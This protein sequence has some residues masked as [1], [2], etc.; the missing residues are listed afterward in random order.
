MLQGKLD[1]CLHKTETRSMFVTLYIYNSK[2][3]KDLNIKPETLK[4]MYERVGNNIL[5]AIGIGN[6]FLNR[7]Q[8][9]QQLRIRIDKWDYMKLKSFSTTK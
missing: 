5:E 8:L 3:I 9:T 2:W 1:I 4:L 6:D 7:T